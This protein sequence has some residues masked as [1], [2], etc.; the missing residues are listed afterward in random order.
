MQKLVARRYP[1][2]E[3]KTL[4]HIRFYTPENDKAIELLATFSTNTFH[5]SLPKFLVYGVV[6]L[7]FG[8]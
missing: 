4:K 3:G 8:K 7:E 2:P 6:E 5:I 1:V